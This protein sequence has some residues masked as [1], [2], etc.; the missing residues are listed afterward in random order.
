MYIVAFTVCGVYRK[1]YIFYSALLDRAITEVNIPYFSKAV[2]DK[3]T[4]NL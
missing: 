1:K 4:V 2:S 3:F